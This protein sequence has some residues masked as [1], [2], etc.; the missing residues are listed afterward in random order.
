MLRRRKKIIKKTVIL[1]KGGPGTG[2][3]VVA[4]N[5]LAALT[6]ED[7]Q[8]AQYTT[9]N[10]APRE[11]YLE[12]LTAK[13][14]KGHFTKERLKKMFTNPV[15]Y[16]EKPD[17]MV[18]TVLCDEAHRLVDKTRFTPNSESQVKDIIHAARCSVFFLDENQ[19]VT[20]EDTGSEEIIEKYA[21]EENAELVKMKL[22]S[23]FRCNGSDGYLAWIDNAL[24]IRKTANYTMDGIDYDLRI[25]DTPDEVFEL[26]KKRN[27]ET[28]PSRMV[29]GYCWNWDGTKKDDPNYHDIKIGD[30][31]MSWNLNN[32][33]SAF[34]IDQSSIDQAG[35]IH[36][37]QGLE[38][39]YVGVIIG[40]DLRYE[41]GKLITD[42]VARAKTDQS[43]RG[44]KKLLK[45]DP[46]KANK[47]ADEII[48]N[49]YRT[50]MTRGMKGCYIYC[51]DKN[52]AEYLRRM[53]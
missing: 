3:S 31:E 39:D 27:A 29:A 16:Y 49:T 33:Q 15:S 2:K 26:I 40:M 38:F 22:K 37:T 35:C 50:L 24:D 12:K 48:R 30:F 20:F 46:K 11:V 18:D 4:V 23:Q 43:L 41:F 19:R 8:F 28:G 34:A 44:Y 7:N 6:I 47:R 53:I 51:C 25:L 5:L 36:T 13:A 45:T 14:E 9:K 10:A 42:P 32:Y 1:V 21:S 17:N 52:L